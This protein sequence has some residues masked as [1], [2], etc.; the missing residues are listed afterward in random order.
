M[1]DLEP[2]WTC[3]YCTYENFPSSVKCTM[4]RGPRPFVS[5]DI[6]Q[7]HGK[8][9]KYSSNTSLSGL[10]AGSCEN[11]SKRNKWTCETCS[12]L[13]SSREQLCVQCGAPA[14]L[15]AH[16]LHEHILPLKIS[17]HSD[18]AQSLSRSRNNSPPASLTNIENSRRTMQTKWSCMVSILTLKMIVIEV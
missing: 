1:S 16:S 7:L 4:C 5:E 14:P 2:K 6:Y 10:A 11:K 9:E 13:N 18:V 8:D 3:E 17:Q 15:S 12:N